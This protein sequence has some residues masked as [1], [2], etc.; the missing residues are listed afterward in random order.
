MIY[1]ILVIS[2][3]LEGVFTNLV[4]MNSMFLPLFSIISL[5]LIYPFIKNKDNLFLY[6]CLML[7]LM[8]DVVYTNSLFINT[9]SFPILG[10]VIIFI[11]NYINYNVLNIVFINFIVIILYRI[12]SYI[13]ICIIAFR[14]FDIDYFIFSIT[15]SIF[16]NIIYGVVLYLI[17]KFIRKKFKLKIY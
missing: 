7:G 3:I 5:S 6:L 12:I 13:L 2:F 17:L 4:S 14:N 1:I 8:Y 10:F 15:H 9:I 11:Y 16:S